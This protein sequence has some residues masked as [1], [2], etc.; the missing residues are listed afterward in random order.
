MLKRMVVLAVVLGIMT[1]FIL[2]GCS[3]KNDTTAAG[4]NPEQEQ[5]DRWEQQKLLGTYDPE[6][7]D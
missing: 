4:S 3:K 6:N 7:P 5:K 1:P 2:A